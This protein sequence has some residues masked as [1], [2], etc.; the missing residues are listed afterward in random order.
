VTQ[1]VGGLSELRWP[2]SSVIIQIDELSVG[3]Q[4]VCSNHKE[5]IL[6]TEYRGF[7]YVFSVQ[8]LADVSLPS[9]LVAATKQNALQPSSPFLKNYA[10]LRL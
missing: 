3:L 2:S 10:Y 1:D 9:R 7:F 5:Q 8:T 6:S 4:S